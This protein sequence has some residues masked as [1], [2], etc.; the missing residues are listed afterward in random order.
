MILAAGLGI[1]M[2][3]LTKAIPKPMLPIGGKPILQH[4]IERLAAAGIQE[5]V[6]NT[7]W[8]AHKI[9]RHFGQGD[10]FGISIQWSREE[11]LLETGGGVAAALP[12]LGKEP[13]LLVSSDIWIEYPFTHLVKKCLDKNTDG[14]LVLV[15]NP[16]HNRQGDYGLK[17]DIV[18]PKTDLCSKSS[19]TFS[20]LSLLRPQIFESEKPRAQVFPL[21]EVFCRVIKTRRIS[22]EAFN[23]YWTDVGTHDRY[24]EICAK[25]LS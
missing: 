15:R 18:I 4:H 13:F 14:H 21:R 12:F 16:D 9:E 1:R 8:L 25:H 2:R 19:L 22:G 23:G 10:E 11:I 7:H 5:V 6:I 17:K 24:L 20:G 3:P